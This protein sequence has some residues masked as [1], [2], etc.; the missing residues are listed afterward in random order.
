MTL[1]D[2]QSVNAIRI[3]AADAVQ[4][5]NSGHPG[6]PL[7]T[8]PM[9]YELYGHQMAHNPADPDWKNRDRFI[10]SGGHGSAGLY[11]LLHL[12]GYPVFTEDLESFRQLHSMTP[13]HPE[14]G[15]TVGVECTTGPLGSGASAAV[16]MAMAEEFLAS[17]FNRPGYPVIDHYTFAE[18]GDGDLMEGISQEALSLAGTL[19]LGKLILLYDSNNIT[20]EGDTETVFNEDVN[21]RMEALGWKTWLV[22]DGN[23]L[24]AI[25]KAIEEAKADGDKPSFIQVRTKIG[26]GSPK[27]GSASSHGEPLGEDNVKALRKTLEWPLDEHFAVPQEVYEH[28]KELAKAGAQK[29]AAWKDM[30][31]KYQEEYPELAAQYERM[32]DGQADIDFESCKEIWEMPA[33][34]EAT[35]VSSGRILN[36]LKDKVPNLIG[37]SADLGPS[38]KTTMSNEKDFT[39][40]CRDGRNLHF[41]VRELGM[42]GIANGLALSGLRPYVGTFFVFSDY[43]KPMARLAALMNLPVIYVFS[44]DS[45]GV[46]EDGPTHQPIEHLSSYRCIPNMVVFRPADAKETA[47][48]WT[49]A[50]ERRDGPTAL[51]L[52]RQNVPQLEET[53]KEAM[54]GAY[55]IKDSKNAQPQMILIASGS[56]VAPTLEAAK[57]LEEKGIDTRVVSMPSMELFER[58]PKEYKEAILPRS[59]RARVAVE[60]SKDFGWGRYVG[61]DGK[62]VGMDS[63]GTSAPGNQLFD[64]FGFTPENIAGAAMEVLE[65]L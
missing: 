18:V 48:G 29:E 5:A 25:A 12:L 20:I 23:D 14:Y 22:E 11:A 64:Y 32:I 6:A 13:G 56:E 2:Q 49:L 26:Y 34:A 42:G 30:Y 61:L 8:A 24:E 52:T 55:I 1:I 3:L 45:I 9:M 63:F 15:H 46:G 17:Q 57:L 44:H 39:A 43:A 51:I 10:L 33:K 40:A 28:F 50:L 37:G 62:V 65:N 60:A 59:V 35:R 27:E 38:N 36:I 47:A 58:Q 41:G 7:G 4:K 19:K 21:K 31:A 16:G 54:K 53:S